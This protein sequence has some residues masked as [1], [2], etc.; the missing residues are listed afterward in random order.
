MLGAKELVNIG[1]VFAHTDLIFLLMKENNKEIT[2][3][4]GGNESDR[5]C[6]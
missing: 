6:L 2:T 3:T 1:R 4:N 5:N